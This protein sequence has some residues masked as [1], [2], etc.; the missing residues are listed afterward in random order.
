MQISGTLIFRQE[1]LRK[2]TGKSHGYFCL[3]NH[4]FRINLFPLAWI[5][6]LVYI[7][8]V[9]NDNHSRY[10]WIYIPRWIT[11]LFQKALRHH[12]VIILTGARQVG[13]STFLQWVEP[14]KDWPQLTLDNLDVQAQARENPA[15]LLIGKKKIVLDEVQKAPE[16]L[17]EIKQFVD[18][19]HR[20]VRVVLTGSANLLLMEKVSETLAGRAVFFIMDSMAWNESRIHSPLD[21]LNRIFKGHFP[22][23]RKIEFSLTPAKLSSMLFRGFLPPLFFTDDQQIIV[24]WWEGY[25][26]TFLERDLRILSRIDSL[27]DF[28]RLMSALALRSG[29]M[30]NQTE[31]SRD[32]KIPQPTINRY[33]NLIEMMHLLYRL[34]A[35]SVNRTKRL[36]KSPKIYWMD[37]G[38]ATFLAGLYEPKELIQSSLWGSI[39]ETFIFQQLRVWTSLQIPKSRLFYWRTVTGKEIDFVIECGQKIIG[40][41]VKSTPDVRFRDIENLAIFLEEYRD[42]AVAGI[43]VYM[44]DEIKMLGEKIIALPWYLLI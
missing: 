33:L 11:P 26:T 39:F 32:V 37:S 35:Y 8:H 14:V 30:L 31:V 24:Q 12:P 6:R 9:M 19:H 4:Q 3:S 2:S 13:K 43:V 15:T 27:P 17:S 28:R 22:D 20:K 29:Q 25:T 10:E 21:T 18:L 44:G 16:L 7:I 38:L 41:E 1:N 36:I 23:E 42:L 5:A 40:I 34:P